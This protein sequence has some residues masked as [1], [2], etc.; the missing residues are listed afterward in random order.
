M[1]GSLK[2]FLNRISMKSAFVLPL[3]DLPFSVEIWKNH[4]FIL[5]K[6]A[7]VGSTSIDEAVSYVLADPGSD[8]DN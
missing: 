5:F 1:C 2:T 8:I 7:N 3:A 4:M 6:M